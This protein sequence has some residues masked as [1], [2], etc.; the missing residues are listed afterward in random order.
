M[1]TYCVQPENLG[2]EGF[3]PVPEKE[4][5]HNVWVTAFQ[6]LKPAYSSC[7]KADFWWGEAQ[8]AEKY[9]LLPSCGCQGQGGGWTQC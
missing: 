9:L 4:E 1:H 3:H 5:K 2:I 6:H 7:P 8:H